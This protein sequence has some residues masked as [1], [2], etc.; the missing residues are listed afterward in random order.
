MHNGTSKVPLHAKMKSGGTNKPMHE[1]MSDM[2]GMKKATH[3]RMMSGGPNTPLF[4]RF[5]GKLKYDNRGIR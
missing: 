3:E 4:G 5:S 1:R 2:S